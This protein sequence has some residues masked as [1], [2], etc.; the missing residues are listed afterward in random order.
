MH[1][2]TCLCTREWLTCMSANPGP[3]KFGKAHVSCPPLGHDSYQPIYV[4]HVLWM[5]L[6]GHV[7]PTFPSL[8]G[9]PCN[10]QEIID[11]TLYDPFE[12]IPALYWAPIKKC[13]PQLQIIICYVHRPT[14]IDTLW[15]LDWLQHIYTH[16]HNLGDVGRPPALICVFALG[17]HYSYPCWYG[18]NECPS[19]P[20]HIMPQSHCPK[21][22]P[23]WGRM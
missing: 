4:F 2:V 23:E 14:V 22:T 15:F 17:Q 6:Q 7:P 16:W 8:W 13:K 11:R 5:K 3:P 9:L 1:H 21:S 18:C 12:V 19:H 10:F 20:P